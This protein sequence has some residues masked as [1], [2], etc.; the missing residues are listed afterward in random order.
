MTYDTAFRETSWELSTESLWRHLLS[1][2]LPASLH[3]RLACVWRD[4]GVQSHP[5]SSS[6]I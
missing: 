4:I 6:S 3:P 2:G 1:R 5:D